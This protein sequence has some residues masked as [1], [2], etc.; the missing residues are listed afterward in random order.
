MSRIRQHI[1]IPRST[2]SSYCTAYHVCVIEYQTLNEECVQ[3]STGPGLSITS[4]THIIPSTIHLPLYTLHT[5]YVCGAQTVN[6]GG[7]SQSNERQ[8]FLLCR[9]SNNDD[10]V[11][12]QESTGRQF[13]IINNGVEREMCEA[14]VTRPGRRRYGQRVKSEGRREREM[15]LSAGIRCCF[16]RQSPSD[17][18]SRGEDVDATTTTRG[19]SA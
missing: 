18:R 6:S 9:R 17:S 10:N 5:M 2:I 7:R 8:I 19:F 11:P 16:V 14:L 13:H 4:P 12:G 3:Y 1:L 15:K